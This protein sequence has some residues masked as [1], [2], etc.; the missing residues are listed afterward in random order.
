M[1]VFK[2]IQVITAVSGECTG[3]D[4]FS[5]M[6]RGPLALEHAINDLYHL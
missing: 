4:V 5:Q 6:V 1:S 2:V 3:G